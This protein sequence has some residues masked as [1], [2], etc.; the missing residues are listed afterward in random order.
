M[1]SMQNQ[2]YRIDS[3]V[4]YV[5]RHIGTTLPEYSLR[6]DYLGVSEPL[7]SDKHLRNAVF[8]VV[9]AT[10]KLAPNTHLVVN[11]GYRRT[12]DTMESASSGQSIHTSAHEQINRLLIDVIPPNIYGFL[13]AAIWENNG[14]L[15][16][17][18]RSYQQLAA[19]LGYV[20][21]VPLR[22]NEAIGLECMIGGGKVWGEAPDYAHF[23]AG[24]STGQFLYDSRSSLDLLNMPAGPLIRSFGQG[25]A[26]FR[27]GN[28]GVR[29]G[30]TFW[31]VNVNL[32]YPLRC[33]SRALIPDELTDI[34]DAQGNPVSLKQLLNKQIDVTGQSMLAATLR[35]E[36][37]STDAANKKAGEM[38]AEIKP[39]T[40]F[41]IDDA[42]IYSIKPLVMFD[43]GGMTAS[44]RSSGE[45]WLAAGG[46]L[47]LTVVIAK[48]EVGYMQTLSGPTF[49]GRGNGFARLVF[50]N[51]F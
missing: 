10:F 11:T 14:W 8:G 27:T 34:E 12:D 33:C 42:N 3:G 16:G 50:Q 28:G 2:F 25:E 23:F 37:M 21:E 22:P 26:G 9:G 47:Q 29:G 6:A 1:K 46:G 5:N 30:D 36:G 45:T 4:N 44:G 32:T 13:R 51:L 41:I 19:R 43:A 15:A 39:A 31:H 35:K 49:G 17:S 18:G 48:F 7:G 24:N 38:L 40:H 20:K